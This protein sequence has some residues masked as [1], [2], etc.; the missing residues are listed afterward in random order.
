MSG[1]KT[2]P[3]VSVVIP[4]FNSERWV[5]EAID[6]ALG[7]GVPNLEVLV[8]NDGSADKTQQIVQE[9]GGRVVLINQA[10]AGVSSARREGVRRA[11]GDYIKF[12]DSDD[13]LPSGALA[14]LLNVAR[15]FPGDAV[16]GKSVAI[17]VGGQVVDENMYNLPVRVPH[18]EPVRYEFLLTQATSSGLWLIPKKSIDDDCF[19]DRMINFGEEYRFCI[20]LIN[21]QIPVRFCDAVVSHVRVH[22]SPERLSRS[23]NEAD[24]L[25]QVGMILTAVDTIRNRVHGYSKEVLVLIARLCWSRG[26]DC[27]RIGCIEAA[28]AYFKLAKDIQPNLHPVGSVAYR[29]VCRIV[30]PVA[31]EKVVGSAKR[32]LN[33]WKLQ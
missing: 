14:A 19:F 29:S 24:H 22:D 18:M 17:G 28:A 7:Q 4:C 11:T 1:N 31:A 12:L 3:S 25:L 13:V 27:L 10:N 9:Y 32:M 33:S 8:V 23:K 15:K 16:I 21:R 5:A 26:R 6:S 30:G 2:A 20:E